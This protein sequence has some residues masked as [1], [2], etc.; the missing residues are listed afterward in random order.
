[1]SSQAVLLWLTAVLSDSI[2]FCASGVIGCVNV[3]YA[4]FAAS[5]I[6]IRILS[7]SASFSSNFAI[8]SSSFFVDPW[9]SGLKY[10]SRNSC[11][12]VFSY[13]STLVCHLSRLVIRVC[14]R[15]CSSVSPGMVIITALGP[16]LGECKFTFALKPVASFSVPS[17]FGSPRFP[18]VARHRFSSSLVLP[19]SSS[20]VLPVISQNLRFTKIVRFWWSPIHTAEVLFSIFSLISGP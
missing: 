11:E 19:F 6:S 13:S 8:C 12:A 7:A 10:L 1:M 20:L 5:W 2:V 18:F 4:A 14:E 16:S 9:N 17:L 3:A 15:C